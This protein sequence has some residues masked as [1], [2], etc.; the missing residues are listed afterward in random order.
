MRLKYSSLIYIIFLLQCTVSLNAQTGKITELLQQLKKPMADTTRISV[1]RKLSAAYSSVDPQKK[2]LYARKYMAIAKRLEI[3]SIVADA[4]LDM[5]ISYGIRSKNDS[6]LYYFSLGYEKAVAANYQRG[7]GRSFSN[8]GFA[9]DRMDNKQE[10]IK[11]Y[12]QAIKIYKRI[13]FAKGINQCYMNIGALYFDLGQYKF[14]EYYFSESL[15][16]YTLA[17]DEYG[18]GNAM[19]SLGNIN[20]SLK[21]YAEARK[22]YIK[23]LEI[24]TKAGD[25]TRIALAR[26]G[27]G[28][29]DS[30][31]GNYHEAIKNLEIAISLDREVENSYNESAALVSL[32]AAYTG[33]KDYRNA[34]KNALLALN[35]GKEIGS[36]VTRGDALEELVKVYRMQGKIKE[37]FRYQTDYIDNRESQEAEKTIND[38][39][40]TDFKRVRS[41]NDGLLEDN[42]EISLR[43]NDYFKTILVTSVLLFLVFILVLLL[44]RRNHEKLQVNKLLRAQKEEIAVINNELGLLNKELNVQMDI[45]TQQNAEL[46]KLNA[47]KNKFFSI[48][49]HDLRSPLTNLQMLFRLYREGELNTQELSELLSRLEET[50]YSTSNFLDNLLEWSKNQLEGMNVRPVNFDVSLL[51]SENIDLVR[52]QIKLKGLQLGNHADKGLMVFADSN[53]INVVIRNLLSNSIKFCNPGDQI[54][55]GAKQEGQKVLISISDNGPGISNE[56]CKKIFHLEHT[57]SKGT[58]G[59]KGHQIGLVLCKDMVEQ[60]GGRIWVECGPENGTIFYVELNQKTPIEEVV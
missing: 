37:A 24:H 34:E 8:A 6:A 41:E 19:Y 45:T 16:N 59:E 44:Y 52:S 10:A 18:M 17:K 31:Q 1:L 15:K 4:Y 60:N 3:D 43:N 28:R 46:A 42:R 26:M 49:S 55:F 35:L 38:V 33:L 25:L 27:L 47:V 5:G 56:D 2:F 39:M 54:T 21:K 30:D 36:K 32:A 9:Y 57:I 51:I 7:M 12:M 29:L 20:R 13:H 40:Q 22:Y 58:Y 23:S 48:V 53:M 11:N 50:I 14:A